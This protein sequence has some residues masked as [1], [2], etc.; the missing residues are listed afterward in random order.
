VSTATGLVRIVLAD[1][2]AMMCEGLKAM[3]QPPYVV[4]GVVHDGRDVVHTVANLK[5]DV[6]LLDVSLPAI[7]GL[8]LLREIQNTIA[9]VK[10]LMLTMHT[11]R[12]YA[13]E[14]ITAGAAGYLLKASGAAELRHAV[15]EVMAGRKYVTPLLQPAPDQEPPS[16]EPPMS[17]SGPNRPRATA[18]SLT[19]RQREVLTLLA[20]GHST[21]DIGQQ[22][23]ISAKTVE[24]HRHAI[25]HELGL[26][27]YAALVRFAVAAG[28]V[29]A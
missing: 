3:L 8:V 26:T 11:E 4:V 25:R 15:A 24:F 21:A 5:P 18:G 22:L 19:P 1:D 17:D 6:L 29:E 10:V 7:N 27:N 16:S 9:G 28:L 13:D 20:Q 12:V 14:A 2:H 23:G